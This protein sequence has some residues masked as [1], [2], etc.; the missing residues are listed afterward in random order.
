MKNKRTQPIA[1]FLTL[2]MVSSLVSI[3]SY[4]YAQQ[5]QSTPNPC[6]T[7][8]DNGTSVA[9]P[10]PSLNAIHPISNE[11]SRGFSNITDV[12]T[13]TGSNKEMFANNTDID[14]DITTGQGMEKSQLG[15]TIPGQ[16][17][18]ILEGG[19]M[20]NLTNNGC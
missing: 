20:N 8:E 3:N 4:S 5:N 15:N 13:A 11:T 10:S 6:I 14:S 17:G 18:T 16:Q 19:I 7:I 12:E 1:Y 9:G 2:I